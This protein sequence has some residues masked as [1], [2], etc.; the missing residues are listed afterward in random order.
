[1]SVI[2]IHPE[3]LF[4]KLADGSLSA[5]ER[6]RLQAHLAGCAPC[7]FEL[8]VRGDFRAE[9]GSLE[10]AKEAPAPS[11][12]SVPRRKLRSG[13][14]PRTLVFGLA[15]AALFIA[16]GALARVVTGE[17][18]WGLIAALAR[19]EAPAPSAP[20]AP[21]KQ[22]VKS[23]EQPSRAPVPS[24]EATVLESES[25]AQAPAAESSAASAAVEPSR[26]SLPSAQRA[27]ARASATTPA[28]SAAELFAS[29]NQAR[30]ARETRRAVELYRSLQQRYPRSPEAELSRLTLATLLLHL[31]DAR[32]ALSAFDAYLA[33]GARPLEAE[34]QVGRAL[35][36][37]ALGL[38]DQEIGAWKVV[39]QRN[40]GTPYERRARE[41]LSAL[42]QP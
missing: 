33:S 8:A 32:T 37:R 24:L 28:P 14:R 30:A 10:M 19:N 42:G 27:P 36:L 20:A 11:S 12:P 15:A 23:R 7:R 6:E 13:A 4:D 40:P 41:R 22:R 9:L 34:A 29:A 39:A 38:R 3:E 1:M 2:E 35:S 5:D 25:A 17:S 26:P 18:P 16:T 21:A 31:G